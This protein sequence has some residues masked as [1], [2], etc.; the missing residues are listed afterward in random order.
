MKKRIR[1]KKAKKAFKK[2]RFDMLVRRLN[3][4]SAVRIDQIRAAV[5]PKEKKVIAIAE[6]MINTAIGLTNIIK[7]YA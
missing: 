7:K 5:A 1:K 4:A 3:F 6:V 2:F